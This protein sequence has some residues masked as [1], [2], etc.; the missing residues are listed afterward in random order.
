[1]MGS[2][3]SLHMFQGL[4]N[5]DDQYLDLRGKGFKITLSL[6]HIIAIEKFK[7]YDMGKQG[8]IEYGTMIEMI[9][10][11]ILHIYETYDEIMDMVKFGTYTI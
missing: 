4:Q 6:D 9:T 2:K 7:M 1:M 8:Y 5:P 11:R 3:L 10:G